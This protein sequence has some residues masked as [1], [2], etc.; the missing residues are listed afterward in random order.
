MAKS[1]NDSITEEFFQRHR[2]VAT[3][4][5]ALYQEIEKL[6]KKK[7]GDSTTA[8]MAKKLN[9]V[10]LRVRDLVTDDEFLDAIE[11]VPVEGNMI[12]MDEAL[13]VLGELRAVLDRQW[14]SRG[15]VN[16]RAEKK[17]Y[18]TPQVMR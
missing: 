9:H 10:I 18:Q 7:G 17:L 6:A 2:I 11:S 14:H 8:L 3:Q 5:D 12:R 15:F 1:E 4:V 13:I 16:Y